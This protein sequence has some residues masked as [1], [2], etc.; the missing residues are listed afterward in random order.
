MVSFICPYYFKYFFVGSSDEKR[1]MA[2]FTDDADQLLSDDI[3]NPSP[4]TRTSK[5]DQLS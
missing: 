3:D 1:A 2:T 4:I 5:L